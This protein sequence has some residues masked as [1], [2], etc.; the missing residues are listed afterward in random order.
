M[1]KDTLINTDVDV[2]VESIL[3]YLKKEKKEDLLPL[4]TSRLSDYARGESSMG[5][6][7]SAIPLSES[8]THAIEELISKKFKAE[9]KFVNRVDKSIIGGIIVKFGDIVID[10][11]LKSQLDR[12]KHDIYGS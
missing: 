9:V 5:E 6:I 8:Q 12:L 10:E 1:A 2:I 4:I 3:S 11:S 7:V